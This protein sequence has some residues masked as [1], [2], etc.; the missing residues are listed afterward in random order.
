M[1]GDNTLWPGIL[2]DEGTSKISKKN[3]TFLGKIFFDIQKRLKKLK[4]TGV[5]LVL[6][7]KNNFKKLENL[8][9]ENNKNWQL[10]FNDFVIKKINWN[11]KYTNIIN[12]ATELNLGLESFVF[13]DDS[14]FEVNLIKSK[15]NKISTFQVPK[16][17]ELYFECMNDIEQLF[18]KDKISKEDK[19]KTEL[20]FKEFSRKKVKERIGNVDDYLKKLKTN[21]LV[22]HGKNIDFQRASE[23]TL[24]FNQF[25]FFKKRYNEN[26]IINFA[27]KNIIMSF[28]VND[29]YGDYGT[30]GLIMLKVI[31]KR[32]KNYL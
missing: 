5:L 7:S 8:F 28:S 6:C 14:D 31:D 27:K 18:I 15:I 20:Y 1:D 9:K 19:I 12:A 16:K 13:L 11:D 23:M 2:G 30:V 10:K 21:I 4:N 26:Q 25:N 17:I 32:K 22:T 29:R 3:N 24:K